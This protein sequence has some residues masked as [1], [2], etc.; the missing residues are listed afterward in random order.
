MPRGETTTQRL[1]DRCTVYWST[2]VPL[3]PGAKPD[4]LAEVFSGRAGEILQ[5]IRRLVESP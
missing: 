3:G 5:A 4:T 2:K 1:P